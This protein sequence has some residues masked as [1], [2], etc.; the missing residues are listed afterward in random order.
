MGAHHVLMTNS[1]I[2]QKLLLREEMI[3]LANSVANT[4]YLILKTF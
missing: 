4:C 3:A 2:Q 1:K